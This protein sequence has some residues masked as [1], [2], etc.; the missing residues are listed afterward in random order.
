MNHRLSLFI[1]YLV[2]VVMF[3]F[4]HALYADDMPYNTTAPALSFAEKNIAALQEVLPLYEEAVANPWPL[5]PE[6]A[7]LRPGVKNLAVLTLR[8]R[9]LATGELLPENN[10]G[11][12]RYDEELT[13]AVMRFQ[14]RHGLTVDGRVGKQTFYEL[15]ISPQERLNQIQVNMARWTKLQNELGDRFILVNVP[16]F[17]LNLIDHGQTILTM[18]AIVGKP[19]R[20]TPEIASVITR[21][22]FNPYW[23]IPK[24][25]AQ[26][27]IIPKVIRD[28]NYLDEM[29]IKILN[30]DDENAPEISPDDIDWETALDDGFPYH[31]RQDPG[32]KNALGLVKF[33]F[34]NSDDVYLHD[35]PAK[36]LF[37]E[38]K[39]DFSSGCIRLEKPFELVSYLMQANP[40]WSDDRVTEILDIG[41]TKYIN[42]SIPTPVIITYLTAWADDYGNIQFRDDIY[43][44]DNPLAEE[45]P[46]ENRDVYNQ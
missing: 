6:N 36:N 25:I 3:I 7:K 42:V 33:E 40:A 31:L 14:A 28:P 21:L 18:K 1:K 34:Q 30:R 5:V 22:V 20:P 15:N 12:A 11:L 17:R 41:K 4:C 35:T 29:H 13:E 44:R 26:N 37:A 39:R 43:G 46:I 19:E 27:D 32:D 16:D 24:M 2:I 9:L 45:T 10:H 23:N 38:D 8:A